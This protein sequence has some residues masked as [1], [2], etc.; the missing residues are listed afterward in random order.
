MLF[1]SQIPSSQN[2]LYRKWRGRYW[3]LYL[4]PSENAGGGREMWTQRLTCTTHIHGCK[5]ISP[6][7]L[8]SS[9]HGWSLC[10]SIP[11]VLL[12]HSSSDRSPLSS[13]E[14]RLEGTGRDLSSVTPSRSSQQRE[15]QGG[16][17]DASRVLRG[18]GVKQ[19]HSKLL[20]NSPEAIQVALCI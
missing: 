12:G 20:T 17:T 16:E 3:Y 7:N 2:L 14:T 8:S 9:T 5:G 4:W 10:A 13:C 19:A 11:P 15:G 18:T 1:Q 6:S